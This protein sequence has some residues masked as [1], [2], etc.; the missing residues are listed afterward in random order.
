MTD[1]VGIVVADDHPLFRGGV[2]KSLEE[3]GGFDVLAGVGTADEA[4]SATERHLPDLALLDISMPGSGLSAAAEIGRRFPAVATVMLT[5][6][7][8]DD[9]LFAAL[10][11]GARGYVLKGV[12]STEL[13]RVL[14]I[15]AGGGSYVSP[16]LAA[17][18]LTA[19][20]ST[21]ALSHQ[22]LSEGLSE[23]EETI[24]RLVSRGLSNKEVGR[25]LDLQ[26]KTVKHYMTNILQKLNVRNRVEAAI[27]ARDLGL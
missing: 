9:D 26:E 21:D 15:I 5:V 16:A 7:E 19:M 17:R 22:A 10:K 25:E 2:I 1:G 6:S 11:A 14:L 27:R 20:Q 4:I 24:L 18:V 13:A 8:S 3:H 23:R 12:D